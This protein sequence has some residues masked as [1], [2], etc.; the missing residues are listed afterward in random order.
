MEVI[1][2]VF[3]SVFSG[4]MLAL[5]IPNEL[6]TFGAPVFT[7]IAF[8][9]FYL[10]FYNAKSYAQAFRTGF[11][12][13]IT[14]H[15]ISSFWLAY[16]KDFA[17]FTLGASAVGTGF[18][19]GFMGFIYYIPYSSTYSHNRLNEKASYA[20]FYISPAFRIFYFAS[21][22]TIYEWVKSSGFLGYPWGTVSSAM[23]RWPVLM[24]LSSITG[25]YG[26]TFLIT[27]LNAIFAEAFIHWFKTLKEDRRYGQREF[28]LNTSSFFYLVILAAVLLYGLVQYN[29]P[30]KA[31]KHFYA[32]LVQQNEDPW[33]QTSDDESILESQRLTEEKLEELKQENKKADLIV[34][35]E[36]VLTRSFPYG[37]YHYSKQPAERALIPFIKEKKVP[38][39]AGGSYI[40]DSEKRKINNAALM[41]DENGNFRGY[42]AK[43]HLVPFAEV[44][45]FSDFPAI[46]SF[47]KKVVGISAGWT[48]GDQYVFFDINASPTENYRLPAV[49]NI[50]ITK[51][52]KE[53]Q[54]E[55]KE[56]IK[57]K[58]S[59]PI[60][61][62][63]AFTDIMR[64]LYMN[65]SEVFLNITDDSWSLKKSSEIQHFV[66]ASYRA[67][68]YRTTLV[69]CANA[70][71]SVV[72]DPAGKI[73]SD[74]PLFE[75]K[76]LAA[77]IP[78]YKRRMTTYARFGNWLPYTLIILFLLYMTYSIFTFVPD[79]YIPSERK[80]K[81]KSKKRKSKNSKNKK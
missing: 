76:A 26:I 38:L 27:L 41:F 58:I 2:Q 64:P 74:M 51:S 48:P 36:G 71:Y 15:L 6:Y 56:G 9:P 49:K 13:A 5:A 39:L 29:I 60:C 23:F 1:L 16:F 67:I 32:V 43:N 59:T 55:E 44:I 8:I 22:Y 65:G 69:R 42:Y 17:I 31:I 10:C 35:S 50:D 46:S 57:V 25:T 28:S 19:G 11:I 40:K 3:Y 14:A 34:W 66:I 62:D 47:L 12:Q 7:L 4:L 30:R 79:D 81:K 70:G 61:F 72:V 21:V 53:Q 20:P 68:E 24:Q 77:D 18:I 73:I 37:N 54:K 45:P 33:K 78:V 52:F 80:T 75:K 63:D